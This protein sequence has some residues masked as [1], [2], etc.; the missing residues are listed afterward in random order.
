MVSYMP[1]FLI[2]IFCKYHIFVTCGTSNYS[3]INKGQCS[4]LVSIHVVNILVHEYIPHLAH[5]ES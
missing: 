1:Y 3:Q 4:S 2:T 5:I